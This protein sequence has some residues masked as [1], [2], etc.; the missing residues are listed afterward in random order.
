LSEY[1]KPEISSMST[2]KEM[3]WYDKCVKPPWQ[4]PKPVFA[5]VWT[6]LY[7][8]YFT[9]L[10]SARHSTA[11]QLLWWGL[12]LNFTWIPS[13]IY[14]AKL[15]VL[16]IGGMIALATESQKRLSDEH[17]GNEALFL[18]YYIAWLIFALTLNL[19]IAFYCS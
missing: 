17:F 18:G 8:F 13:F 15:G 2:N 11:W 16:V 1:L 12:F 6:L 4:P 9:I 14:N 19:F 5:V 7:G 3:S 10:Y